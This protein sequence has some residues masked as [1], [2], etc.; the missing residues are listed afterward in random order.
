MTFDASR[1]TLEDTLAAVRACADALDRV[2]ADLTAEPDKHGLLD[3]LG[4]RP[5]E[6][7]S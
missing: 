7:P 3:R 2:A 6:H 1:R 4:G 5:S